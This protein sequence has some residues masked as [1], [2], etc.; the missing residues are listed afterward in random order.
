MLEQA[1]HIEDR[2]HEMMI[3]IKDIRWNL[4]QERS[5][6]EAICCLIHVQTQIDSVIADIQQLPVCSERKN[7]LYSA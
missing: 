6:E 1:L 3:Q 4:I 7:E 2:L 5:M